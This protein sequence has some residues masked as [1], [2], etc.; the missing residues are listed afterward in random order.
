M[1]IVAGIGDLRTRVRISDARQPKDKLDV[2]Y[3]FGVGAGRRIRDIVFLGEQLLPCM[4]G[5]F[6]K[7]LY[8]RHKGVGRAGD[9]AFHRV[10]IYFAPRRK[11]T[12]EYRR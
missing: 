4:D 5:S 7:Y 11:Q 6:G 2:R 10:G 12:K 8:Q 3:P 1:D 9:P